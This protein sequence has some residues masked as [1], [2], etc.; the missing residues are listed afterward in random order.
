MR[1]AGEELLV[2]GCLVLLVES[3]GETEVSE[4]DMTT[5][6]EEDVVGFDV[7]IVY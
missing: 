6:V 4:F 3:S 1:A 7:T 2:V 5:S